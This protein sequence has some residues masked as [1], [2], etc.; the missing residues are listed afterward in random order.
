MEGLKITATS[1][2]LVGKQVKLL[3]AQGVTPVHL[4][5]HGVDSRSL[6]V[7][8]VTL[9]KLFSQ[10]GTSHLVD[11]TVDKTRTPVK[12]LVREVQR[13]P[14]N[15]Q[16]L[17]VDFFQVTMTEEITVEV[18]VTVVGEPVAKRL[19]VDHMLHQ[20]SVKC[21]PGSIPPG[22][23]LDISSLSE[24][25]QAIL[26]KDIDL[27]SDVSVNHDPDDIIVRVETPR[28]AVEEVVVAEE[29]VSEAETVAQKAP[30][31]E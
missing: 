8:T 31:E 24:P 19:I 4:Y 27:G 10:A 26:I 23:E 13:N 11:L 25:G 20:L 2:D 22:L 9:E 5:G 12:V 30:S 16:L 3:R 7:E 17:H 29:D 18:P 6:Q 21:L 28:V 14:I 15:D 1:R